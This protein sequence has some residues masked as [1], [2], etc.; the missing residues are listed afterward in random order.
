MVG[1]FLSDELVGRTG[2][3]D[4]LETFLEG[5]LGIL[6]LGFGDNLFNRTSEILEKKTSGGVETAI[7]INR[8]GEGFE[9]IGEIGRPISSSAAD[10]SFAEK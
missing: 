2:G 8:P 5:S 1:T 7:E 4:G 6:F 10:F 9:G 3:D